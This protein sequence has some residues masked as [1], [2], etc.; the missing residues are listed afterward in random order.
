MF[1]HVPSCSRGFYWVPAGSIGVPWN[2]LACG[3][4]MQGGKGC[5]AGSMGILG[6][7]CVVFGV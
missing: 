4:L 2:L 3:V 1:Y 5:T 7:E 6:L